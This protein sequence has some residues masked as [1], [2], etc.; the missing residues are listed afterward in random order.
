MELHEEFDRE[1]RNRESE[2]SID[3][4]IDCFDRQIEQCN[5]EELHNWCLFLYGEL[6]ERGESPQSIEQHE[7]LSLD[8][9]KDLAF[10]KTSIF[11]L[12]VLCVL[13]FLS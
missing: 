6:L 3:T 2:D 1:K 11:W 12:T 7:S 9:S 8:L 4:L 5:H 10:L 13:S